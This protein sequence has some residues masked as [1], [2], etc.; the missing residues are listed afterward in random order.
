MQRQ[1]ALAASPEG[2]ESLPNFYRC[3]TYGVPRLGGN[4][5]DYSNYFQIVQ[6]RDHFV[7]YGEA[8]HD[9][10]IVPLDGRAHLPPEVR[11]W[12]GDSVGRFD[13]NAAFCGKD[14]TAL[15]LIN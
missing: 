8:V 11:S 5:T 9:A 7:L 14:G 3:I 4:S 1:S 6:T 13:G 10:R 12:N 2:P 15:V